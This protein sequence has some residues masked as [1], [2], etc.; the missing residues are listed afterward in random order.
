MHQQLEP[1]VGIE[2]RVGNDAIACGG[3]NPVA[4]A[5]IKVFSDTF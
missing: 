2:L 4:S 5:I 3:T 1:I